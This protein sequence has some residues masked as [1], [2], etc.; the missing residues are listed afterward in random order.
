MSAPVQSDAKRKKRHGHLYPKEQCRISIASISQSTLTRDAAVFPFLRRGCLGER[1]AECGN[2]ERGES[3]G[4]AEAACTVATARSRG[5]AGSGST[6][7]RRARARA[8]SGG[9]ATDGGRRGRGGVGGADGLDL[10]RLGFSEDLRSWFSS[11]CSGIM[12]KAGVGFLRQERGRV[13]WETYVRLVEDVGE[14]D[15]VASAGRLVDLV[16]GDELGA[17]EVVLLGNE[18]LG[19]GE[20]LRVRVG[21]PR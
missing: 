16:L 5:G 4:G 15:G 21:D 8:G 17:V 14:L 3:A 12:G 19:T 11:R 9:R 2:D 6:S 7:T 10:E 1:Q 20:D 18:R 13:E